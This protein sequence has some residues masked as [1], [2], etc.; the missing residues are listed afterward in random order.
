MQFLAS[1]LN[2]AGAPNP[3]PTV[4]TIRHRFDEHVI[5]N[6]GDETSSYE[7]ETRE[8]L[9]EALHSTRLSDVVA[10]A[11]RADLAKLYAT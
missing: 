11:I 3:M 6:P 1:K 7:D 8:I 10:L 2:R 4:K 5:N 9:C